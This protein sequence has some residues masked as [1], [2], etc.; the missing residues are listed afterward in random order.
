MGRVE[1]VERL[2]LEL[3][4]SIGSLPTKYL[5]L[6][7]GAKH[8]ATYVWDEVEERLRKRLA[9]WKR[10]YI[11]K[12][13]RLTRIRS[14]LSNMPTYLMSLFRLLRKVKL[15]LEKIQ[16]DFLWGGGNLERKLHLVN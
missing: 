3:G 13:G 15:R 7:L 11:S 10:Q 12:G 9:L 14:T 4:C 5:G 2:A 1:G 8:R 6:P 16:Q